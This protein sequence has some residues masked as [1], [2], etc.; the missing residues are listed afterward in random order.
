M[1]TTRRRPTPLPPADPTKMQEA[2]RRA[3]GP[4]GAV[5]RVVE[6]IASRTLTGPEEDALLMACCR[7][8]QPD[9]VDTGSDGRTTGGSSV[10]PV[11]RGPST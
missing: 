1:T 11:E 3:D 2:A 5:I 10:R 7:P 6:V 8:F 9:Y 4:V